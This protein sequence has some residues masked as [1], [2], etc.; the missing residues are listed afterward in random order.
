[1]RSNG[2]RS[3]FDEIRWKLD[4]V[5]RNVIGEIKAPDE[6]AIRDQARTS[7]NY[8]CGV[9]RIRTR[10]HDI[11]HAGA[12]AKVL[13]DHRF[14]RWVQAVRC[15]REKRQTCATLKFR[16][17][18]KCFHKA[19]VLDSRLSLTRPSNVRYGSKAVTP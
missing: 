13:K 5:G 11:E 2:S 19:D 1:M 3:A 6:L 12:V 7:V 10:S 16:D 14:D 18:S 8:L 9:K 15:L 4:V 17:E